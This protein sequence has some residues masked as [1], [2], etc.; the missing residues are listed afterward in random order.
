MLPTHLHV[1]LVYTVFLH[2]TLCLNGWERVKRKSQIFS[3]MLVKKLCPLFLLTKLIPYVAE[4]V[5]SM[6]IDRLRMYQPLVMN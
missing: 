4:E 3:K 6:K 2:R 5:I 1:Y